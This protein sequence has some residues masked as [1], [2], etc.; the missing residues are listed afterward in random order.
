MS[1]RQRRTREL[2][3]QDKSRRSV[4]CPLNRARFYVRNRA[5]RGRQDRWREK[6]RPGRALALLQ[7]MCWR[8]RRSLRSLFGEGGAEYFL[9]RRNRTRQFGSAWAA[10]LAGLV[11]P[12]IFGS[13][14]VR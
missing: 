14:M 4:S 1:I 10:D 9:L 6:F 3:G 8:A 5:R 13:T 12:A 7:P 2:D 11:H